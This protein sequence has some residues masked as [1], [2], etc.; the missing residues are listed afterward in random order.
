ILGNERNLAVNIEWMARRP[1]V[2]DVQVEGLNGN[3]LGRAHPDK[4]LP[5]SLQSSDVLGFR[6][7]AKDTYAVVAPIRDHERTV[8]RVLIL[9]YQ[10]HFEEDLRQFFQERLLVAFIMLGLLGI[11]TTGV[12]WLAIRPLFNLKQTVQQILAGDLTARASTHSFDEI[13]DLAQAFNEMVSRLTTSFDRLRSRTEALKES[14]EKYRLIVEGA[15]DVIFTFTSDGDL[16]LLNK[17]FFGHKR[18]DLLKGGLPL[19]VAL[20]T[21]ASRKN[22]LET[23]R[24]IQGSKEIVTNVAVI[25]LDPATETELY[26]LANLTPILDFEGNVKL[27][28]CAMRDLTEYHRIE[29]MKESLIRDVAHELRTPVAKFQMT[30]SW[31][32]KELEHHPEK[33]KYHDLLRILKSNTDQ[34]TRTISSIMDLSKMEAGI[35][36]VTKTELNLNEVL[37]QVF[38]DMQ[39]MVLDK[40]LDF[41]CD[42]DP[43]PISIKGDRTMLQRLFANLIGNAINFTDIGKITLTSR[44]ENGRAYVSVSDTG[45]GIEQKDLDI[46]FESFV[47]K[48][49]S[50][51]GIG[52]GLTICRNIAKLH[53]GKIWAESQGLGKGSV[54]KVEFMLG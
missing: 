30:L 11:V 39:P 45:L 49:A 3:V 54:F 32:E 10:L 40:K 38:L 9:F 52:V 12:T 51:K 31:F 15:S 18:E 42:L 4:E 33:E 47:Q 2:L 8:G 50:T 41:E 5:N 20:Q 46:I 48:T 25:H 7:V 17:G 24:M 23:I 27:I 1:N 37:S 36:R 44:R 19:V 16:A 14:E 35:D 29:V 6:R 43:A 26:Y 13:S 53:G 28:Q 34:L 21:P 22:F